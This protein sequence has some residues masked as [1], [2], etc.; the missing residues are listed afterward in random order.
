MAAPC[1]NCPA[2]RK[3]AKNASIHGKQAILEG[4]G[5]EYHKSAPSRMNGMSTSRR[6]HL[7]SDEHKAAMALSKNAT[8][9]WPAAY[10]A[11]GQCFGKITPS[12]TLSSGAHGGLKESDK[13]PAPPACSFHNDAMEQITE[14]R[15]WAEVH[16]FTFNGRDWPFKITN[17][18][19]TAER[20]G[21]RI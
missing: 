9:C 21:Q 15:E 12:H 5:H 13:Y 16:F 3:Q 10:G 7:V 6:A 11:P 18:W 2:F 20:E 1:G 4:W 8:E 17:A 14:I 19:L